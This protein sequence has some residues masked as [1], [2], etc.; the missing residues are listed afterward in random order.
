M[1]VSSTPS[2]SLPCAVAE[3]SAIEKLSRLGYVVHGFVYIVIGVL[4]AR[5]AWGARGALADPPSAI[6]L[7]GKQPMGGFLV[8]LIGVGLAAYASWRFIQAT[9]DPDHQ[10]KSI[11]GLVVRAG[12]FISGLGYSALAIFAGR[13]AAGTTNG[14]DTQANWAM[15][16]LTEPLGAAIGVLIA[17]ILFLVAGDDIRKACTTNFGERLKRH[18]MNNQVTLAGRCAGS[19]GFA[20]RATILMFGGAYLMRAVIEADP[21]RARNFEGILGSML[22][23]P[24]GHWLLAFVGLGLAAYGLFMVQAGVYRKH[25]S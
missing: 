1:F 21:N 16:L 12:R 14:G 11:K 22:R 5:L 9:A 4:A 18:K 19:W 8:S 25:P 7:I 3:S 20:A 13:L 23:L 10:G 15:R 24:Y 17:I 6:E 2:Q